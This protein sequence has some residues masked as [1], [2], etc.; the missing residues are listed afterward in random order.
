VEI[1]QLRY[2]VAVARAG[3]FTRAARMLRVAQPALSQQIHALEE[4]TGVILIERSNRTR[5]LTDAGESFLVRAERI[6]AEILDA[7]EELGAHAGG[8][9]GT[10]RIGC[11]LQT[12]VEGRLPPLLAE[13]RARYPGVRILFREVHTR[14]VLR[15]LARGEVDLGLVHLARTGSA[16]PV[17]MEGA[18]GE[19]TLLQLYR[20]PLLLIVG[21]GHHL[22]NRAV[23]AFDEVRDEPFVA[24]RAGATVRRIVAAVAE[25]RGFA[26][27][28]AFSTA[29]MSTVR[30][31]VSAGLGVAVVPESALDAAGPK[32]HA[33]RFS[34]ARLERIVTLARNSSR[35]ESAAVGAMRQL[36]S[37]RLRR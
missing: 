19:I 8:S 21:P 7:G 30:A 24:F 17:G 28:I 16:P 2:F 37:E 32:L 20:E 31:L 11:A 22:A 12:L 13:F 26:P 35:Y 10:V 14:Q 3:S 34:G 25:Q 29:S 4:E 33:I 1:R 5:G 27:R 6:L 36:L 23:A 9:R 15:L 18:S